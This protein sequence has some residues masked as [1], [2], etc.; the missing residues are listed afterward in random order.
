MAF[1]AINV[2]CGVGL[3]T[4]PYAMAITGTSALLLLVLIGSCSLVGV[5]AAYLALWH[6]WIALQSGR[7]FMSLDCLTRRRSPKFLL[8]P[9]A[10]QLIMCTPTLS[11]LSLVQVP[12]PATQPTCW[13]LV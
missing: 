7:A 3:L 12:S 1:N 11:L 5:T 8:A 2:L 13:L 10:G 6:L 4:T 9:D